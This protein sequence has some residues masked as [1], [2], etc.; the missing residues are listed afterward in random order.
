MADWRTGQCWLYC[1]RSGV[2]VT[3][4]GTVSSGRIRTE[5]YACYGCLRLLRDM[6]RDP[7]THA[8]AV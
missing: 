6:V 2:T 7:A 5:L 4:I 8:P 3:W 1:L